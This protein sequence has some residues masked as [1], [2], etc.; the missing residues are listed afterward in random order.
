MPWWLYVAHFIAGAIAANS[1]PHFVNGISGR[2]FVSPFGT[3]PGR[4][5]S[6]AVSN[7]LWGG[8]NMVAAFAIL[9]WLP[10]S[11]PLDILDVIV[12]AAG[13]F[14]MAVTLAYSFN[15]R[16]IERGGA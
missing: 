6:S 14:V 2:P 11:V 4:G 7:V 3:P 13:F 5:E 16:R 8:L 9:W 10:M 15:Q 1:V 12:F